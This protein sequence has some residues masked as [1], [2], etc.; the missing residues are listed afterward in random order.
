MKHLADSVPRRSWVQP[1]ETSTP[2]GGVMVR[3]RMLKAVG[4][5]QGLAGGEVRLDVGV[6]DLG[7][8]LAG[9]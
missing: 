2:A 4:E 6:V 9:A 8:G 3:K 1:V 7:G 5:H